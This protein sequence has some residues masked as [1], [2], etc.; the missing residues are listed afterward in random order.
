MI[1]SQLKGLKWM[2]ECSR[3]QSRHLQQICTK[4]KPSRISRKKAMY[5][6]L[7]QRER[8]PQESQK[9]CGKRKT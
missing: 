5:Q 3:V 1:M 8:D 7:L 2:K 6:I 9:A 4:A